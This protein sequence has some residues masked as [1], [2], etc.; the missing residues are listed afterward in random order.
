MNFEEMIVLLFSF[1]AGLFFYRK[2]AE[3]QR[4][5]MNLAEMMV[6][7]CAFATPRFFTAVAQRRGEM[8]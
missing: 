7:L 4:N 6:L 8:Q 5:A 1:C 2:G 3:T